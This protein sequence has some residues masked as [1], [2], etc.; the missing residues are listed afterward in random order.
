MIFATDKGRLCNNILQFGHV[1][2]W[3]KEHGKDA[4]AMR[5]CY[6]YRYFAV[7]E[8]KHYNWIT[9]L[10]AKYSAKL[11]LLPTISFMEKEDF[12]DENIARL[13]ACKNVLLVGW[14]FRDYEAFLRRQEEI[15][16]MFT[17]RTKILQRVNKR[18]P[19]P[20]PER[21][22]LGVHIRRGD[23]KNFYEGKYYFS[24]EDFIKIIQSFCRLF[25]QNQVE[26]VIVG[27]EENLNTE[28]YNVALPVKIYFPQGNA[29]EDLYALSTCHY[30]IGPP[31]T[32]SLMAAFYNDA[33]LYWIFDKNIELQKNSFRKFDYWFRNII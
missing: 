22:R 10:F 31:S 27:N 18:I 20:N 11:H 17:F 23:Y 25:P 1:Y 21:I 16:T 2:A 3:A 28:L 4:I 7:C 12:N 26:V 24:D 15:K 9:Y 19:L 29:G 30:L 33:N 14:Y 5:F 13:K 32:F 8:S 6:K